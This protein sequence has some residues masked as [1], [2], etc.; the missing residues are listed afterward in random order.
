[1]AYPF[2]REPLGLAI[3]LMKGG[4]TAAEPVW[5][6]LPDLQH[7]ISSARIRSDGTQIVLCMP[8]GP[9]AAHVVALR[10]VRIEQSAQ[11]AA[12]VDKLDDQTRRLGVAV[13][14]WL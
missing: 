1:M 9:G 5:G 2:L 4:K 3:E 14:R 10:P 6:W 8:L 11:G 13:Q 7:T 12:D